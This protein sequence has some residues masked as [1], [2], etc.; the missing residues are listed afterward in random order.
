MREQAVCARATAGCVSSCGREAAPHQGPKPCPA[1][2]QTP[3]YPPCSEQT[4]PYPPVR[5]PPAR[6]QTTVVQELTF[7][8]TSM[9]VGHGFVAAGGQNSQVRLCV[10]HG[11]RSA[12]RRAG[13]GRAMPRR[14]RTAIRATAGVGNWRWAGAAGCGTPGPPSAGAWHY[15]P[16]TADAAAL[17]LPALPRSPLQ[18]DVRVLRSGEVVYKGH[19]GGSVNNALHIARDAGHQV[20]VWLGW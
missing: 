19:C 18:L 3:P 9:T 6:L 17:L 2:T 8:P 10:A 12:C 4:P 7:E 5:A 1:L 20:C 15:T 13:R 16:P 14:A 11:A